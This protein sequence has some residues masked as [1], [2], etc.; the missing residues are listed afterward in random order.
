M[1]KGCET[2]HPA[3][4][5][6]LRDL[7][8]VVRSLAAWRPT[9]PSQNK[10][11][12][13]VAKPLNVG[14]RCTIK[15]GNQKHVIAIGEMKRNLSSARAWQAGELPQDTQQ[16]LSQK[17]TRVRRET[18]IHCIGPSPSFNFLSASTTQLYAQIPT[19]T[20][21]SLRR[22]DPLHPIVSGR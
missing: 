10:P 11:P 15:F 2:Q 21:L 6:L 16:Q 4:S 19:S 1:R 13:E 14:S 3:A 22:Q 5:L 18:N 12:T 9:R 7:P 8:R 20:S 17:A